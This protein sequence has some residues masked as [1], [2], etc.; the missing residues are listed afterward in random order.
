MSLG[1]NDWSAS[2]EAV[3]NAAANYFGGVGDAQF[4]ALW[5]AVYNH[6]AVTQAKILKKVP[7]VETVVNENGE[8]LTANIIGEASTYSAADAATAAIAQSVNSNAVAAGSQTATVNATLNAVK[9]EGATTATLT[10]GATKVSTGTSAATILGHVGTWVVGAGV[11]LKCG[12]WL[13]AAFYE[14]GGAD[15][16]DPENAWAYNPENWRDC[17]VGN[18]LYNWSGYDDFAAMFNTDDKQLY[19][20][21]NL[22]A[23][24]A[25]YLASQ[26]FF[27]PAN[28]DVIRGDLPDSDFYYPENL[29]ASVI[30]AS[31]A[32]TWQKDGYTWY[33][34]I[35]GSG[36]INVA[37]T[38]NGRILISSDAQF[39]YDVTLDGNP[40]LSDTGIY[41]E[42]P[43]G[44][45]YYM[46]EY[47]AG[48]DLT[49][50]TSPYNPGL[51]DYNAYDVTFMMTFGVHD[52]APIE[53]VHQYDTVPTGITPQMTPDQVLD[54]L[55]QQYP[56][57]FDDALKQGLLNDDG[58]VTDH[59][60]LPIGLPSGG[61]EGQPE[62]D[63]DHP[64]A[65]DPS[66]PTTVETIVKI[67][68][69]T[70]DPTPEPQDPDTGEGTTPSVTPPTGT[71]SALY[72][73]YNPTVGEIASFGAWLWSPNFVDQLLKMFNDPMQAIISLHKI[74][75][76]PHVGGRSNI[77]VGYLDS[78][79]ASNYVDEQYIDIDCGTITVNEKSASVLDYAPFVD[80]R[81]F[82]PFIGIVPLDT[83]DVM[84]G[85][86]GVKYRID[87]LTG[88]L[89]ATV[90]VTRDAGAGGVIYQYTGSCAE[91]YP[92][93]SG[94]YMGIVTGMLGIAAGVA[95]TIATGGAAAP[96]LL[97]GA[98]GLTAMHTRVEHSNGFS[99]NAGALGCKKPYLIISR[100]QS[101]LS[102][103]IGENSGWPANI[104]KRLS[105]CSGYVRVKAV[106]LNG[107]D[108]ATDTELKE[109]EALLKEGV[110]I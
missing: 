71:A 7:F 35:T 77:K 73:I 106:H 88:T 26:G 50:V 81:L 14:S 43:G 97:G 90:S 86:L 21:Q 40:Y 82:L 105:Q 49:T 102:N 47:A 11:G 84:R 48:V 36:D 38:G 28:G 66:N 99:G 60:Y 32:I 96:A 57:L 59:I 110:I 69:P 89:I 53:G 104:L 92:L 55:R 100:S 76:T 52:Q 24:M 61:P 33:C 3:M 34:A 29:P 46:A 9:A 63:P 65:V 13:D 67:I 8:L 30:L 1:F 25:Q 10:Q 93:S 74:Y 27:N 78:G 64:G 79:V 37:I 109:I 4:D 51:T 103:A 83:A 70:P 62:T 19:V 75:G 20:D 18:W 16:W 23:L 85:K 6:D 80:M 98:A 45:G 42:S 108:G 54:L 68:I 12:T 87:V 5:Q 39:N 95:G 2:Y 107:I 44:T 94:S 56:G 72:K 31:N 15:F 22:F 101:A 91:L 17:R 58:T 41:V